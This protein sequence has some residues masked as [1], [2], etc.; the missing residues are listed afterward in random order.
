MVVIFFTIMVPVSPL[1][2]YWLDSQISPTTLL[3]KLHILQTILSETLRFLGDGDNSDWFSF[4]ICISQ[5]I[6]ELRFI[7][8]SSH[9]IH[10][11]SFGEI[12][13]FK[14]VLTFWTLIPLTDENMDMINLSLISQASIKHLSLCFFSCNSFT[15]AINE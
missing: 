1:V 14:G 9:I 13:L 15:L 8:W 6:T 7:P 11:R 2:F 4:I 12:T 5:N 3:N 10:S